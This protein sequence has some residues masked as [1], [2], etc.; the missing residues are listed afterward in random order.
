M[1]RHPIKEKYILIVILFGALLLRIIGLNKVPPELFGDELDVGYQ[2]YSLLKTGRDYKGQILPLYIHSFSEWRAPLLMYVTVPF[3]GV[4]GSNEW[5]V[6]LPSVFFALV[7]IIFLYLL[8]KKT[9][10]SKTAVL[11][12]LLLAISP[13]HIQY[14]RAAFEV[15]LLLALILSAAYFFILSFEKNNLIYL[16]VFL[17]SLAFYTYSTAILFIPLFLILLILLNRTAF[18]K[19]P[20][21]K[22]VSAVILLGIL[23]IPLAYNVFF[24]YAA[25]RYSQFSI[26]SDTEIAHQIDLKRAD[27]GNNLAEK[28]FHNKPISWIKVILVNYT[29]AFSPQFLFKEGDVTFRHSI[30]SVGQF[31][32]VE[33]PFVLSGIY[34]IIKKRNN[35]SAFYLVW[36]LIAAIPS[37][38]TKDGA[39]HATR[40]ILMLPPLIV[41]TAIGLDDLINIKIIRKKIFI[42]MISILFLLEFTYYLHS[43]FVDYPK[44]SWRW[45]HEG[46]K[47]AMLF[48][49]NSE[50]PYQKIVFNNTYEPSLIRFL[51]WWRYPPGKF[52]EIFEGDKETENILPGYNGFSL[53]N[54]YFF[55]YLNKDN[56]RIENF[57]DSQTLYLVSHTKEVGGDWDW[58]N[59]PPNNIKVLKTVRNP[60]GQPIFYVITSK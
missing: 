53:E 42:F 17:F 1:E 31:Y 50:G 10:N 5:G 4:F 51:F 20:F 54:K 49:K 58:G 7:T 28:I 29:S 22:I 32:W 24:G 30:H 36:L 3:V 33:L 16:S 59:N 26:F 57:V 48:M 55:G 40:L 56:I 37:S 11:S 2:A 8:V 46:Y 60:Y 27:G 12:A 44:E 43:Y 47:E 15:S 34:L 39:V 41:I 18:S 35:Q 9:L 19:F 21:R 52:H 38:L 14:S 23:V 25:E 6:R 45:W 13:W